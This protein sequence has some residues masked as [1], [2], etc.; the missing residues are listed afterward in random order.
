[1]ARRIV[2]ENGRVVSDGGGW[3]RALLILI[4]IGIF[5]RVLVLAILIAA[6]YLLFKI[7]KWLIGSKSK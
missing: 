5:A 3:L 4:F 6:A 2:I 1:M 7:V